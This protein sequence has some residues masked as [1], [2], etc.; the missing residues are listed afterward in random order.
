MTYNEAQRLKFRNSGTVN[1]YRR[2]QIN[3]ATCT[4][5]GEE[6]WT[7]GDMDGVTGMGALNRMKARHRHEHTMY[8]V[9]PHAPRRG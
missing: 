6:L 7:E 3:I 8:D 5:C 1:L 2:T 9:P 4:V